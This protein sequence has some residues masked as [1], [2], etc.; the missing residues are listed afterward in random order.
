MNHFSDTIYNTFLHNLGFEATFDQNIQFQNFVGVKN[1]FG[2]FLC[3]IQFDRSEQI[4][5]TD[6]NHD[7]FVI[8]R[9]CIKKLP[10]K[11]QAVKKCNFTI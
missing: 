2:T 8:F 3:D 10:P 4:H 6:N 9:Q 1:I 5:K 11:A 7:Q